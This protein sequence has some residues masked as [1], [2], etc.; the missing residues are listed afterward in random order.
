M[1]DAPTHPHSPNRV[2]LR[3]ELLMTDELPMTEVAVFLG[4]HKFKEE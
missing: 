3:I 4:C 1:R 2:F